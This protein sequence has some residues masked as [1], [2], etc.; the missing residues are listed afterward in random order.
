MSLNNGSLSLSECDGAVDNI[1]GIV[2]QWW[3]VAQVASGDVSN[4]G[5]CIP[6]SAIRC[7]DDKQQN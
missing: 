3:S 2:L 7:V 4:R 5:P 6:F 1:V